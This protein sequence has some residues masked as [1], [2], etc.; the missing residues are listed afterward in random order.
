MADVYFV[1]L[2]SDYKPLG[3]YSNVFLC[4]KMCAEYGSI[5]WVQIMVLNR[6]YHASYPV[7]TAEE[8]KNSNH[9]DFV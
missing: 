9:F 1:T 8:F 3:L 5:E 4:K 6:D 7:W 2:T